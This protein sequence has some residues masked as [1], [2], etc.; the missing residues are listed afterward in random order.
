MPTRGQC[1]Q[2][3]AAI[4]PRPSLA[5]LPGVLLLNHA[6]DTGMSGRFRAA[7]GLLSSSLLRERR[8]PP[9]GFQGALQSLGNQS[10][11]LIEAN[12]REPCWTPGHLCITSLAGRSC[13]PGTRS[14]ALLGV[15]HTGQSDTDAR[16][17]L[18]GFHRTT[19]AQER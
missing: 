10:H 17:P 12:M 11:L 14:H 1:S 19:S 13:P 8:D 4:L 5:F 9:M 2:M 16:C 7:E 15:E 3:P 6:V 18:V